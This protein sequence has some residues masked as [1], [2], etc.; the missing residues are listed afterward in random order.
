MTMAAVPLISLQAKQPALTS[1]IPEKIAT[2]SA[3]QSTSEKSRPCL[4]ISNAPQAITIKAHIRKQLSA[5]A[6]TAST[7]QTEMLFGAVPLGGKRSRQEAFLLGVVTKAVIMQAKSCDTRIKIPAL[8][9]PRI[10]P[11]RVEIRNGGPE[12]TQ[13]VSILAPSLF[14]KLPSQTA[15]FMHF[16]PAG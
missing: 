6:V 4:K 3:E 12:L 1:N 14:D 15:S 10:K 16:A 5:A 2:A 7:M 9:L 8:L 11:P 13:K